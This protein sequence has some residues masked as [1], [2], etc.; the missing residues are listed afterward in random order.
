MPV[1]LGLLGKSARASAESDKVRAAFSLGGAGTLA[2]LVP[3]CPKT[4]ALG[5][6]ERCPVIHGHSFGSPGSF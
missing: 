1:P 3:S 2:D 4:P 6:Q 5:G